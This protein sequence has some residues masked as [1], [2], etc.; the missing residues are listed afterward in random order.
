L[1]RFF[2]GI[3]NNSETIDSNLRQ[4]ADRFKAHLTQKFN[5]DFDEEELEEDMP[6]VVELE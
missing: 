1:T 4:K 3:R 5:W 2:A 6:V